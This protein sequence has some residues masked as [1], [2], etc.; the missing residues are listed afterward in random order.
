MAM[1]EGGHVHK[2][3]GSEN[4]NWMG[5]YECEDEAEALLQLEDFFPLPRT[6]RFSSFDRRMIMQRP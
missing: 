6:I 1:G 5:G 3:L 4:F 2:K